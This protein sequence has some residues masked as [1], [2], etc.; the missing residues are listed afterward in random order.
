MHT[1]D[2]TLR[3]ALASGSFDF[4]ASLLIYNNGS[5]ASTLDVQSYRL[6]G[7][8]LE[9]SSIGLVPASNPPDQLKPILKRRV[10]IAGI[11]VSH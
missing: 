1:I 3:S 7:T 4:F 10:R 9:V 6:S 11:N 8:E 5:L 2:P